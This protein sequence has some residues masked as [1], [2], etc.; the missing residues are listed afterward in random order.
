VTLALVVVP[1]KA[2]LTNT[3]FIVQTI[4]HGK[5][6]SNQYIAVQTN[7]ATCMHDRSENEH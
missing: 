1:V 3:R 6:T 5:E 2:L 4:Y 7:N